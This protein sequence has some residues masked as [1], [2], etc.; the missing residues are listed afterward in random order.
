MKKKIIFYLPNLSGGGAER[1]TI[2]ILNQLNH[3]K[4]EIHLVLGVLDGD[5]IS[6]LP[7]DIKVHSLDSARTIYSLLKLRKKIKEVKPYAIFSSLY[8]THIA[9]YFSTKGLKIR[10][11]LVMRMP[12]SPKLVFKYNEMGKIFK[13]LFKGAW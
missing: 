3:Q 5:A 9:L 1:V 12:S 8:R 10:P 6:I 4:Y 13:F 7:K 11:K 2:N